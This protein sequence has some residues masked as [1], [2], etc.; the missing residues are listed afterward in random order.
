MGKLRNRLAVLIAEYNV[1]HRPQ[2]DKLTLQELSK[3]TGV[4]RET[5][6]RMVNGEAG[7]S[8][9]TIERLCSFF[10]CQPGDLLFMDFPDDSQ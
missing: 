1:K 3:Q 5:L 4:A 8:G 6:S 7:V 2:Q 9:T 10:K